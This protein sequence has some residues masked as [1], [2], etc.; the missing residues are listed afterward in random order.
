M[1]NWPCELRSALVLPKRTPAETNHADGRVVDREEHTL[2]D[3]SVGR[4][5]GLG[6]LK[7]SVVSAGLRYAQFE[8]TSAALFRGIPGW[9]LEDGFLFAAKYMPS[10]RYEGTIDA[11]RTFEGT[12]VAGSWEASMAL[13]GDADSGYL[14]VDWSLGGGVLFGRQE[15][16]ITGTDE[17][18]H[19]E[20]PI[21][22]VLQIGEHNGPTLVTDF[23]RE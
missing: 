20:L 23:E 6:Q 22:T 10:D 16:S 17:I 12:G 4:D 14:G 15:T 5:I 1:S 21:A 11:R 13:L 3:F 7:D 18:R 19:F 8:S 2:V 9:D